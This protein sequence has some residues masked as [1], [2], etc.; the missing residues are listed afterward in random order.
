MIPWFELLVRWCFQIVMLEKTLGSPLD[1]KVIKP[2]NL[3]GNQPWIFIG[4]IALWLKLQY[5]GH[6][7]QWTNSLEKILML[8]KIEVKRRRRKQRMRRLYSITD[9]MDMSSR[10]RWRT[11]KPGMPQSVA[12]QS[13]TPLSDW[14]KTVTQAYFYTNLLKEKHNWAIKMQSQTQTLWDK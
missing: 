3:E 4:K 1:S 2:V 9:S 6:L 5:L 12:S 14:T 8:G 10:R 7:M 11:D 13:W